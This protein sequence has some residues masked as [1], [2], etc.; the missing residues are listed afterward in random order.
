GGEEAV[1]V[2]PFRAELDGGHEVGDGVEGSFRNE[3]F[4]ESGEVIDIAGVAADGAF[5]IGDGEV[6]PIVTKL[7]DAEEIADGRRLRG[8]V[9]RLIEQAKG[10]RGSAALQIVRGF[11]DGVSY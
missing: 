3:G 2:R 1:D 11:S 10:M 8:A 4:A 7:R 9:D 6:A 5:E